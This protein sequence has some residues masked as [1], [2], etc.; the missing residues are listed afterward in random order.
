M[1]GGGLVCPS[2]DRT[3]SGDGKDSP[4]L[5]GIGGN[6][7]NLDGNN[8]KGPKLD[9]NKNS[10]CS[11]KSGDGKNSSVGGWF[12][13]RKMP[14]WALGDSMRLAHRSMGSQ[15][16]SSGWEFDSS[17]SMSNNEVKSKISSSRFSPI[18]CRLRV[19][20]SSYP[21]SS[22]LPSLHRLIPPSMG[23][24]MKWSYMPSLGAGKVPLCRCILSPA[25]RLRSYRLPP[26]FPV[27]HF[28]G[29]APGGIPSWPSFYTPWYSPLPLGSLQDMSEF[30]GKGE[31][32]PR[33]SLSLGCWLWA[34]VFVVGEAGP[35]WWLPQ[36]GEGH[37]LLIDWVRSGSQLGDPLG[38][39]TEHG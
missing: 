12:C 20:C 38:V 3:E 34:S 19:Y 2:L 35:W 25:F 29:H 7:P 23:P 36:S 22:D 30:L 10:Q 9:D 4:W 6:C 16:F 18:G 13:I 28:P 26:W 5:D 1:L 14:S 31:E 8:W 32:L 27:H 15:I 11:D 39:A 37:D 24:L 21:S 33:R 17:S